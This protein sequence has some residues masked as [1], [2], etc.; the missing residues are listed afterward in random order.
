MVGT[1]ITLSAYHLN[2]IFISRSDEGLR[3]AVGV[4]SGVLLINIGSNLLA[5]GIKDY[6]LH[7]A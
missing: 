5:G 2:K 7:K 3:Y 4:I 1:G 6:T